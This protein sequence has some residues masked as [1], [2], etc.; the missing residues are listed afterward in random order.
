MM[1]VYLVLIFLF[2]SFISCRNEHRSDSHTQNQDIDLILPESAKEVKVNYAQGFRLFKDKNLSYLI[3]LDPWQQARN[4]NFYYVIGHPDEFPENL[5]PAIQKIAL[6]LNKIACMS[7]T[8]IGFLQAL[9][10]TDKLIAFSGTKYVY[11]DTVRN[12]IE[13]GQIQEIGYEQSLNFEKI[14]SLNPDLLINYGISAEVS[15]LS[16]KLNRLG[17]NSLISAE[18][19]EVH[20]LGKAEWIKVFGLIMQK[21]D[22]SDALFREMENEY[23]Q[24]RKLTQS[25]KDKPVVMIGMP[26]KDVWYLTGTNSYL[27][28]FIQD[29]GGIYFNGKHANREPLALNIE[30]VYEIGHDADCWINSGTAFTLEQIKN[31]DSRLA[32][33]KSFKTGKVYNNNARLNKN[34]GYDYFETGTVEPHKIL[35]ELIQLFHPELI[36]NEELRYYQQLH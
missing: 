22:L 29:A 24:L 12:R 23:Q 9:Q 4:I 6:P 1:R 26:W 21:Q 19:L 2:V 16:I 13:N 17:I 34:G 5:N 25:I 36:K 30:S 10:A 32:D 28:N 35:R 31:A 7:T 27:P 8:H 15:A 11:T 3:V 20:P 14:I 33:F 18:Y